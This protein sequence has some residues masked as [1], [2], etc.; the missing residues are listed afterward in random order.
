M[1]IQ[2]IKNIFNKCNEN[3]DLIVRC[4]YP[5]SYSIKIYEIT[6]CNNPKGIYV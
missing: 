5:Y 3:I 2:F 6:S 4:V 1:L